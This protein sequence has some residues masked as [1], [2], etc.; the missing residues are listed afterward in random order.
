MTGKWGGKREGA[1]R[2]KKDKSKKKNPYTFY[3]T[4][5]EIEYIE[6]FSKKSRSESLRKLIEKYSNLKKQFEK[7]SEK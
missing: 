6:S 4:N 5:D 7:S 2:K 3:L 1:G